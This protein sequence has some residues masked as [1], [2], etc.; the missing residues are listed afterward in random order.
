[1]RICV[2]IFLIGLSH[3]LHAQ[4]CTFKLSGHVEDSDVKEKLDN[5]TIK[6]EALSKQII[7]NKNGDFLFDSL[8]KG[9]Y[10]ILITHLNCEP[11]TKIITV[12]KNTHIDIFLPH[13]KQTLGTVVVEGIKAKASIGNAKQLSGTQLEQARGLS[14]A[15]ALS[16]IN[17]V[18]L[19]Q[20]GANIAK[21]IVDGLHSSR[22]LTI[23]NG[24]RQEGQQ[25]GSEH[26]IEIDPFIADKLVII[27][28][29]DELKYGSDAIGGVILVE[30]KG[31][32][33]T[34][35]YSAELNAVYFSNNRQYVTSAM[36]EAA[37]KKL[38]L[39][40]FRLQGSLKK[41]ANA[42]M[43]N[44]RLNNTGTDEKN[45]SVNVGYVKNKINSELFYSYFNTRL[46]IFEGAHIGNITDLQNA[47]ASEKPNDVFLGENTY[48]I[49]RP[50]QQVLHQLI[51]SK[52]SFFIANHKF[53][54]QVA[55]QINNRKEFDIVRNRNNKS[56]QLDLDIF[57][58][59]Q[60][61]TWEKPR[62]NN[63]MATTGI[64]L[65]QQQNSY[66]SRYFI[67]NY[68]AYTFGAYHIKKWSKH[69]WDVQAGIR[70]DNK[71]ILTRRLKFNGDT[72]DYNFNFST[73]ASSF[74]IMYKPTTN[75]KLNSNV[76]LAN[77]APQVN[78]L[79]SDGIHHGTATYD[80]GDILLKQERAL[81]F[82]AG[83]NFENDAKTLL[84]D[85][86]LYNKNIKNFIYQ[87]P[88]P[89]NPVL[90]IAGAFPLLQY[91]QADAVLSGVDVTIQSK[92]IKN[93]EWIVKA[94]AL[95]AKN[96][97]INDWLIFMPANN[98]QNEFRYL[99]KNKKN[100]K[101]SYIST[102]IENVM[103]QKNVPSD[104]NGK[105]DYKDAPAGFSLL[106][107][108]A[109]TQLALFKKD[110]SINIGIRNMLNKTY[111]SYLNS[112]RYFTDE[113]GRNINV[114]FKINL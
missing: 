19:L 15:D 61:I 91:V 106:H 75:W 96:K 16:K 73:L 84:V 80:K 31:L 109:N 64:A 39:F 95:Q 54:V 10:A 103:K 55:G 32:K 82:T 104:K 58:L 4:P 77:R 25:W 78:E 21:P 33:N 99:V 81:N 17:G 113:I 50:S 3:I 28:G 8:C 43:P 86:L 24:V 97:T 62:V 66:A 18:S 26:A 14:L 5:A 6:I 42:T 29:V 27:R 37:I 112:M 22:L 101:Y 63:F 44:Y 114:N 7:T 11:I 69:G 107:V 57:T 13:Q 23:N 111:R 47:I 49:N 20:T 100:E 59:S 76:S 60:D 94:A 56:P 30:P 67:P 85:V 90:T 52:T 2:V 98:L 53:T 34:P 93:V 45:F 71:S 110:I 46:G 68:T 1:M 41:G 48:Q 79:L 36:Y 89:D 65:S 12:D 87:Q 83:L 70:Y 35:G 9:E 51:K 40:R 72:L 105:Q 74:S 38:P 92:P 88:K 102:V 108:Y